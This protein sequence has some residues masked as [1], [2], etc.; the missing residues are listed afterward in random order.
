MEYLKEISYNNVYS[1]TIKINEIEYKLSSHRFYDKD[2]LSP[3]E[4]KIMVHYDDYY[5][6]QWVF[7][8]KYKGLYEIRLNEDDSSFNRIGFYLNVINNDNLV[9]SDEAISL[10]KIEKINKEIDE[11]KYYIKNAKNNYY[12]YVN[13]HSIRDEGSFYAE[14]KKKLIENEK[15]KFIFSLNILNKKNSILNLLFNNKNNIENEFL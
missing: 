11:N 9:L 12:L 3:N 6:Q 8:E 15:E 14:V 7:V 13:I 1:I 2:I 4:T 5:G 10:W